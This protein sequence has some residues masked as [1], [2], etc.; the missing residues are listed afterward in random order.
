MGEREGKTEI[1]TGNDCY[2]ENKQGTGT[3]CPGHRVSDVLEKKRQRGLFGE[4]DIEPEMIKRNQSWKEN[5]LGSGA[6][7]KKFCL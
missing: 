5:I 6:A 4:G 2:G 1:S 7:S 3:Q